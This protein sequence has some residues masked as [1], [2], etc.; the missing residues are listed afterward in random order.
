MSA[1]TYETA[2]I[3]RV[4]V[5]GVTHAYRLFG[6][7]SKEL[8]PLLMIN[9]FRSNMDHWDP[10]MINPLATSRQILQIDP[11]GTGHTKSG[12]VLTTFQDMADMYANVARTIGINQVDL[13]GF[14][15][16]SMQAQLL[17]LNQPAGFVRRLILAGSRPSGTH[18]G[19]SNADGSMRKVLQSAEGSDAEACKHAFCHTF[20]PLTPEKQAR[21]A[22]SWD[23]MQAAHPNRP[24]YLH[25]EGTSNL[26]K[27]IGKFIN[28][29]E[30]RG[31]SYER[32]GHLKIPVLVA[33]GSKDELVPTEN[34]YILF[35]KLPNARLELWPFS[36]HGFLDEYAESFAACVNQFLDEDLEGLKASL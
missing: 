9:H 21:A 2:P 5:N 17:A 7:W 26:V 15:I 25:A 8:P 19:L 24:L 36:G 13:I 35:E 28:P 23:R 34:S 33:N 20:F 27:A 31:K 32:L 22:A 1:H 30:E 10:L 12:T 29:T 16:G 14:S 11:P 3:S 4:T 18:P 6:K